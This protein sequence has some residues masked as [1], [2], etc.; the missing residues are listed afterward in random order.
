MQWTGFI[1]F[2]QT[3][4]PTAP[5]PSPTTGSPTAPTTAYPTAETI[6]IDKDALDWRSYDNELKLNGN[7]FNLKGLNWFG[8]ETVNNYPYGTDVNSVEWYLDWMVDNGFNAIRLPFSKAFIDES[9]S[10]RN[11]YLDVVQQAG[12]KGLLVMPDMHSL[13][14]GAYTE[15]LPDKSLI[16]DA[17]STMTTLLKDEWNVFTADLFNVCFKVFVVTLI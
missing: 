16:I 14:K 4:A 2:I 11:D 12:A 5:T 3:L 15:G 1:V 10:N 17:W 6:C 9:E 8:F 13:A 7:R